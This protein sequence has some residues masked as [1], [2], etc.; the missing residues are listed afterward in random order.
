MLR[1]I[2]CSLL[3]ASKA[4]LMIWGLILRGVGLPYE[5]FSWKT[6]RLNLCFGQRPLLTEERPEWKGK[7]SKEKEG[8]SSG[9][10]RRGW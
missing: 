6:T 2:G 9:K 7:M 5:F 8:G 10:F 4:T 1:K 3:S